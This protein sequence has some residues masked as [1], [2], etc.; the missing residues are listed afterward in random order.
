MKVSV[1]QS[2]LILWDPMDCNSPGSSVH[3]ILQARILE[4]VVMPSS[5]DLPNPGIKP[6]S[7]ISAALA[8]G[9][10]TL[11]A[12]WEALVLSIVSIFSLKFLE[13]TLFVSNVFELHFRFSNVEHRIS[14]IFR[15]V[16]GE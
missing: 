3:G 16:V 12:T 9:F 13:I 6:M 14:I 11:S 7:F 4:W 8:G 5:R 15:I 10:F 1:A 2:C